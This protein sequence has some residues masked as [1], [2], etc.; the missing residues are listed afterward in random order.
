[1][2]TAVTSVAAMPTAVMPRGY[3]LLLEMEKR[4]TAF[5]QSSMQLWVLNASRAPPI[6]QNMVRTQLAVSDD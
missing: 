6:T 5:I 3:V 2:R 1:M 4:L